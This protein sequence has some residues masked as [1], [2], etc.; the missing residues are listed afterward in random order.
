MAD[1]S[2]IEWTEATPIVDRGGRRT[3]YYQ[4]KRTDRPG[5][6]ERREHAALGLAWCRGC[7]EWLPLATVRSGVCRPCANVEYRRAY[8]ADG[9]AIRAQKYARKRG[10]AT[11]PPWWREDTL[12]GSCAY[13]CGRPATTLDHIMPV[14]R[15]GRSAPGNLAPTCG[16]CNSSKKDSDPAPWVERGCIAVPDLWDDLIALAIQHGTDEWLEAA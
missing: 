15:G 11:I 1:H 2:A 9:A 8:A 13:G 12:T 10:L 5:A 6:R 7:R 14:A 4:R 16:R 3:R